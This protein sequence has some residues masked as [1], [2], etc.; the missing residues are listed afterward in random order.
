[1]SALIGVV[2]VLGLIVLAALSALAL[3]QRLSAKWNINPEGYVSTSMALGLTILLVV[4]AL[5]AFVPFYSAHVQGWVDGISTT[6]AFLLMLTYLVGT[7]F[8]LWAGHKIADQ[9]SAGDGLVKWL[10]QNGMTGLLLAAT[11]ITPPYVATI[12]R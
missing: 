1:M 7:A 5:V 3:E 11:W 2:G 4:P 8:C 9:I 10:E 12:I 6:W